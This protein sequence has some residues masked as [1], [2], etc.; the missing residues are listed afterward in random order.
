MIALFLGS[1]FLFLIDLAS[2]SWS[3]SKNKGKDYLKLR[4]R[5]FSNLVNINAQDSKTGNTLLHYAVLYGNIDLAKYC[6]YNHADINIE[7]N[8]GKT[9]YEL[10]CFATDKRFVFL[11]HFFFSPYVDDD[12]VTSCSS[13]NHDIRES[14]R[15]V[16]AKI[17][18][19]DDL[20][21]FDSTR[22]IDPELIN[23]YVGTNMKLIHYLAK[24]NSLRVMRKILILDN[25]P[26]CADRRLLV[27]RCI[28][29]QYLTILR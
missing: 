7:N 23:D 22:E 10:S 1:I 20:K 12:F 9:A 19:N 11:L 14:L 2:I 26:N 29:L 6:I 28:S 8:L 5:V 4:E 18:K 27:R 13:R 3:F 16:I 25:N 15:D 17:C 21:L 24:Y